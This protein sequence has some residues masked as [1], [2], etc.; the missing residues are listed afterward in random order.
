[1]KIKS[2]KQNL[3][4]ILARI[5]PIADAKSTM[6]ILSNVL[7][8]ADPDRLHGCLT[9]AASNLQVAMHAD[10]SVEVEEEGAICL[11]ARDLLDRVKVMPEGEIRLET[12]GSQAIIKAKSS[13]RCFT[14][15]AI[16]AEE[17][18]S[19]PELRDVQASYET[20]AIELSEI[21][22]LTLFSVSDD[23]SRAH[24]NSLSVTIGKDAIRAVS[25]DGHRLSMFLVGDEF[26]TG[27][28]WLVPKA[29]AQRLKALLDESPKSSDKPESVRL[30]QSGA[31]LFATCGGFTMAVKLISDQQFPPWRQV[32]PEDPGSVATLNR[33]ELMNA[34]KALMVTASDM[35]NGISFAFSAGKLKLKAEAADKGEGTDE[36][37]CQYAGKA[38]EYGISGRYMLDVLGAIFADEVSLGLGEPLAPI[39]VEPVG[40]TAGRTH[41]A[42]VMPMRC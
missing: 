23:A 15:H 33:A 34:I 4:R 37:A 26:E 11:P 5:A 28:E 10:L 25:T 40:K 38:N 19:L 22:A 36:I 39:R 16:P 1:M 14:L 8:R 20:S 41:V 29:S 42:I 27:R 18:P 21:L 3:L 17:F 24:L 12:K 30:A 31:D 7:L 13:A 6:P 32:I 9:V 35:S 2:T